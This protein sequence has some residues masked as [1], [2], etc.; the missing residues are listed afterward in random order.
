[1]KGLPE[2]PLLRRELTELANRPRTYVVRIVGAIIILLIVFMAYRDAIHARLTMSGGYGFDEASRFAGV[3]GEVFRRITPNL[4]F[5]IQILMPA[6]CCAA[7]TA[8]KESHTLGT[9]LLTKLSPTVIIMEKFFSRLVPMLTLLILTF[10]ILAHLYSLGGVDTEQLL[11]TLWLLFCEC[12]LFGSIALLCSAWFASTVSAFVTAYVITGILVVFSHS[13]HIQTFVPS[14][15]WSWMDRVVEPTYW[16]PSRPSVTTSSAS[17]PWSPGFTP[18]GIIGWTFYLVYFVIGTVFSLFGAPDKF[19][20]TVP[21]LIVTFGCLLTARLVLIPRAFLTPTSVLIRVF[22][23]IDIFFKRINDRTTGG[24]E[25]I[26]D[27]D[28]LPTDDPVVWR[29]QNKKSLGKFRY[30]I[31]VLVVLEFPTLFICAFAATESSQSAFDGL[32]FLQAVV[33]VLAI[34]VVA[35]KGATLFSSERAQQTLEPLL[36][37]PMSTL[38]ILNQ[39]IR[40]MR[41]LMVVMAIPVLTVSLTQVLLRINF[42]FS[43]LLS[44]TLM[45]GLIYLA[46]SVFVVWLLFTEMTWVVVGIGLKIHSQMKAILAAIAVLVIWAGLPMLLARMFYTVVGEP[47][48]SFEVALFSPA[49][50]VYL[51]EQILPRLISRYGQTELLLGWLAPA[52]VLHGAIAA[53]ARFLVRLSVG[54]L[55]NRRDGHSTPEPLQAV[56]RPIAEGTPS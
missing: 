8:E 35:V 28:E 5:A 1:M 6:F 10:P 50:V 25:L 11:L 41:R 43:G 30:L 18:R 40:G 32:Y 47:H 42:S 19:I 14:A 39:K 54:R 38:E 37:T 52:L 13:L 22:Q 55:L 15:I 33:W 20:K 53:G 26:S 7:V 56:H 3:G 4:F 2:L 49:S 9:L 44:S 36:S 24:I 21:C 46:M 34:L 23:K 51:T 16:D 27:R 31:R 29:E 48:S 12:L 17:V 45:A